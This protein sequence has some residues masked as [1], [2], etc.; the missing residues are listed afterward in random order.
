MN[1]IIITLLL[2]SCNILLSQDTSNILYK[3]KSF[4]LDSVVIFR[5]NCNIICN[6]E[7]LACDSSILNR[8]EQLAETVEDKYVILNLLE[9]NKLFQLLSDSLFYES[10][11]IKES[12]SCVRNQ[13][14][15]LIWRNKDIYAKFDLN[16]NCS[17]YVFSI[18]E[19]STITYR[20]KYNFYEI[21]V[22]MLSRFLSE[23]EFEICKHY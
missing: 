7:V 18:I 14:G 20:K 6:R 23:I 1:K 12:G 10:N 3:Y 8:N 9:R 15:I 11:Y 21:G 22:E 19:K 4:S 13:I 16:I 2:A 5:F 17:S